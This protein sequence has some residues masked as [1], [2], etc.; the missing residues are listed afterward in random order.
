MLRSLQRGRLLFCAGQRG[1]ASQMEWTAVAEVASPDGGG[2][3]P[4]RCGHGAAQLGSHVFSFGGDVGSPPDGSASDDFVV[5]KVVSSPKTVKALKGWLPVQALNAGPT[6][7]YG[8]TLTA[9]EASLSLYMA[10]GAE[11][12]GK[13]GNSAEFWRFVVYPQTLSRGRVAG[14]WHILPDTPKPTDNHTATLIDGSSSKLVLVG[15]RRGDP[16]APPVSD[17]WSYSIPAGKWS[18][19]YSDKGDGGDPDADAAPK[20]GLAG[21]ATVASGVAPEIVVF[22]PGYP[23]IADAIDDGTASA[24]NGLWAFNLQS[25]TWRELP[26]SGEG[27]SVPLAGAA[28]VSPD[29]GKSMVVFGGVSAH[30][31][32]D[33]DPTTPASLSW[34]AQ[35]PWLYSLESESWTRLES[36][37]A[38][39]GLVA[40]QVIPCDG[41]FLVVGGETHDRTPS[42]T[43]Y[44]VRLV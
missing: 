44:N 43:L 34:D 26:G 39:Q 7:R 42:M 9:S 13:G 21:H 18:V 35:D 16:A 5:R 29:N 2:E 4:G 36:Q 24:G 23:A 11:V 27:P 17:V 6:A 30:H 38:P 41:H 12:P 40:H 10:G 32:E 28:A 1:V 3:V 8:H 37:G 15:G 22:G 33:A 20:G 31:E 14:E 25:H 19:L